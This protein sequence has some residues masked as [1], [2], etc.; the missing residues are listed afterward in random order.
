MTVPLTPT[1]PDLGLLRQIWRFRQYGRA[2]LRPLLTGVGMRVGELASDLATPWPLAL[3]IDHVLKGNSPTGAL[4]GIAGM[5]G[6][7]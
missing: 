2:E 1:G 3:I 4:A 6:S 5:F 7:T